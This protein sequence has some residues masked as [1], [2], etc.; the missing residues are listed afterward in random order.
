MIDKVTSKKLLVP[1]SKEQLPME[2]KGGT[3]SVNVSKPVT[4]KEACEFL[5]FVK[6]SEY[7][8]VKQLNKTPIKISVLSLLQNFELHRNTFMK[9]F[10]EAYVAHNIFVDSVD[11]L[12]KN[13]TTGTFIAFIDKEIPPKGRG[14]TK[15]V[16]IIVKCK[17]H[18]MPRALIDNGFFLNVL[19]MSTLSRLPIDFFYMKKSHMVVRAF[20][21][22][23]RE[24]MGNIELPIQVRTCTFNSEFIVMDINPSYT[25]FLED[26]GSTWPVQYLQLSIRKSSL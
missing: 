17:S 9:A 25:T 19:P 16:Y 22:M 5:K 3:I 2:G 23:K 20:N 24:V 14:T 10:D 15:A 6:H 8:I 26:H 7:S 18:I 1:T 13:I 21:G 12:I 11:Q 4:E